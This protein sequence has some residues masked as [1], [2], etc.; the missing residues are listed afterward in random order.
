MVPRAVLRALGSLHRGLADAVSRDLNSSRRLLLGVDRKVIQ[1]YLDSHDVR[2][3]H[4]GCGRNILPGWL[5]SDYFP[6]SAAVLH[7][8]ARGRFPFAAGQFDY[9]YSEHMIEHIAYP[10]GAAMVQESF[11]VLKPGGKLRISTPDLAFLLDLRRSD[12]SQLQNDYI[13]WATEKFVKGAPYA[14]DTFV[15]NNFVRRWGHLF[16]YDEKTLRAAF[17]SAGFAAVVRCNLNESDD[18]ALRN[19]ENEKRMPKGF[20]RLETMTIEGTKPMNGVSE[21]GSDPRR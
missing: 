19:L 5:N 11:R 13:Q 15:I 3:L 8:D 4:L 17:V 2:K 6:R 16:I 7:L 10:E 14:D 20:L 12:R 9:V 18:S 21:G 1:G